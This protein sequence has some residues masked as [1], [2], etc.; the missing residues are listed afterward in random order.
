[1]AFWLMTHLVHDLDLLDQ[2]CEEVTLSIKGTTLDHKHL[3][4]QCPKL[5][6]LVSEMLR[7]TVTSSLARVVTHACVLGG[8]TLKPGNKIMV[9][10]PLLLGCRDKLIISS[11]AYQ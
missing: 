9:N 2:V 1:M 10:S 8:K 5:D 3:A 4:K 6:S 7:L 11:A